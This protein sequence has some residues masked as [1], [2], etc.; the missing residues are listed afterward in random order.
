MTEMLPR[1]DLSAAFAAPPSPDLDQGFDRVVRS[2]EELAALFDAENIAA[3]A[4][5]AAAAASTRLDSATVR[6]FERATEQYNAVLEAYHT[7]G[8]YLR[9]IVAMDSRDAGAQAKLSELQKHAVRLSQLGTRFVAFVGSLPLDDLIAQSPLAREHAF[10]LRRAQEEARHLMSP[11]EEA[12]AAELRITGGSAWARL[13]GNLTSQMLVPFAQGGGETCEVPMSVLRGLAFDP[14]RA[15]RRR[16][17]EA[18]IAVWKQSALPL[19]AAMNSIKGEANTLAAKRGWESPLA[20]ALWDN[21]IDYATL[22]AL[23]QAAQDSFPD[24]RRYLRAKAQALGVERLTWYDLFAPLGSDGSSGGSGRAWSWSE[25]EAFV[26]DNFGA[27]SPALRDF[28]RRAFGE[29]WIDAAPRPG[30]RDGAFCMGLLPGESR[31]GMNYKPAFGGVNTLAHELGHAYHNLQLAH[32]TPLQRASPMT[33]AETASIFCETIV[34]QAALREADRNEEMAILEASLESATQVVVDITSRFRFEQRV[35][36]A[37]RERELSVDEF[38][39]FM[40]EAQRETYGD[41]LDTSALHPYMWAVKGHYYSPGLSFY[42]F[43]YMFGLLFGLGLYARYQEE[44]D[45]FRNRYDDLLSETGRADAAELASR[46]GFD[47]RSPDFWR[48]SLDILRA[49]I[50][51]FETL[52]KERYVAGTAAI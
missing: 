20:V 31:I 4:A 34:R 5:A 15:V 22:E 23:L 49:E 32:R 10:L 7:L 48:R 47:I 52:V 6:A 29:R 46:F 16:A 50:D 43:P 14:D 41:G 2:I 45:T 3:R 39:A 27:Y 9:G 25:A 40:E 51:R 35:F 1:W 26:T 37:R 8:A 11:G 17:Y 44:P 28:A 19:A 18:E 42:N 13:H 36:A 21:H 24:F 12:L 38:C 33:L 30:K